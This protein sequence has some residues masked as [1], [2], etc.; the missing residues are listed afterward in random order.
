MS[1]FTNGILWW[2]VNSVSVEVLQESPV[3]H[4]GELM[5]FDGFLIIFI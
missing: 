3:H 5:D 2:Q 4:I 1:A